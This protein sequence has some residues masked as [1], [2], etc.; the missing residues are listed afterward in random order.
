MKILITGATG[1]LGRSLV[2]SAL[3]QD[4][5]INF[6]TSKK[7]KINCFDNDRGFYYRIL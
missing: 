4:F 7:S 6:L 1:L 5:K 3:S 2:K